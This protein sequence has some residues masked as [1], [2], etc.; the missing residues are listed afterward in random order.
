MKHSITH[1]EPT[2]KDLFYIQKLENQF[3]DSLQVYSDQLLWWNRK[4]NLVS[5]EVSRETVQE[6]VRH[7]LLISLTKAFQESRKIIDTGTGGG[8]PGLPLAVCFKEKQLLLNDIVSKKLMSVRQM[9]MRLQLKNVETQS[10]SIADVTIASGTTVISK[11]AF[12]VDE[13]IQYLEGKPWESIVMLKGASEAE[14]EVKRVKEP[15]SVKVFHL[16]DVFE[17][18]FYKGKGVV[19]IRRNNE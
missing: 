1:T 16:E 17:K 2:Q 15:L 12:K 11:H 6:H 5:R 10:C 18:D 3:F 14:E 13:L 7:S 4:I 19:E 9:A 8:L